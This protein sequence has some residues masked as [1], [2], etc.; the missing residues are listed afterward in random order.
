MTRR[1]MGENVYHVEIIQS[2]NPNK[3]EHAA[4][5]VQSPAARRP[6]GQ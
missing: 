2:L 6:V 4:C 5:P 3:R 1:S